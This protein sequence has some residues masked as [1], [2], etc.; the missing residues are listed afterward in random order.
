LV[1]AQVQAQ[2]LSPLDFDRK[3]T[4]EKSALIREKLEEKAKL[5]QTA[6]ANQRHRAGRVGLCG[7]AIATAP[8]VA[9]EFRHSFANSLSL[10]CRF[11]PRNHPVHNILRI[12]ERGGAERIGFSLGSHLIDRRLLS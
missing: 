10:L 8:W 5:P 1:I 2:A 11:L 12:R 9:E 6:L 3:S 4:G 7:I